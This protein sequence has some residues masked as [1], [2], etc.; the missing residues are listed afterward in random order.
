MHGFC[1]ADGEANVVASI[2]SALSLLPSLVCLGY[3]RNAEIIYM[4][5]DTLRFGVRAAAVDQDGSI[6]IAGSWMV[7][8]YSFYFAVRKLDSS[9]NFVWEYQVRS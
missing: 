7:S 6:V 4:Q 2:S 5:D 8:Q 1:C 9:G 3:S